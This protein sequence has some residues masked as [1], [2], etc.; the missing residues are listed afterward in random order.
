[1]F[2][3]SSSLAEILSLFCVV[4]E[5]VMF[6]AFKSPFRRLCVPPS[7]HWKP[8]NNLFSLLLKMIKS[9]QGVPTCL[10]DLLFTSCTN[11]VTI[12]NIFRLEKSTQT[13]SHSTDWPPPT[14]HRHI[15]SKLKPAEMSFVYQAL[16]NNVFVS[17]AR[18][19]QQ[20]PWITTNQT[21]GSGYT[22][23]T[24]TL[25][26]QN[27]FP[28]PSCL[29]FTFPHLVSLLYFAVVL[30]R[31]RQWWFVGWTLQRFWPYLAEWCIDTVAP[32]CSTKEFHSFS[33]FWPCRRCAQY[34]V[35]PTDLSTFQH[36]TRASSN[37][38]SVP[39]FSLD[40]ML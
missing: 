15:H 28:V 21:D 10:N 40:T 19:L 1:M 36:S 17:V 27:S 14:H 35:S 3:Q 29:M 37:R 16:A 7:Q 11:I 12:D 9:K 30:V 31:K 26:S 38:V 39:Y 8:R 32:D 20:Q 4:N 22:L 18:C 5:V 25:V 13:T 33:F 23:C 2:H 34:K 6:H 24:K